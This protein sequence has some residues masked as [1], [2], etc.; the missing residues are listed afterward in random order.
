[1]TKRRQ[2]LLR[3]S[4][5][6]VTAPFIEPVPR[7]KA[8]DHAFADFVDMAEGNPLSHFSHD[9]RKAF[10]ELAVSGLF[11]GLPGDEDVLRKG[12]FKPYHHQVEMLARGV[13]AGRPG[14]VTSGTGSG[15]TESFMLPILATMAEEAVTWPE[16]QSGYLSGT[17]WKNTPNS[18]R[19]HREYE[20]PDR[21][22]ALRAL[23]LYPM[24]ALVE[25]QL[26]RLR[27]TFDSPEAH[28][29][30]DRRF[31]G[32]R[33]FF[34]RYT[35]ATPV[36]GWL[37]HPRRAHQRSEQ[38][39][40]AR[41]TKRVADAFVS[42]AED[43][44]LAQ[45]HDLAHGD[46]DPTRYLFP[47]VDGAELISRW[48]MQASPPDL[49]VTNISMLGAMLSREIEQP[50]FDQTRAWLERDENAYFFLVLDEL[51]L[52]R[53]SAGTE[54]AGLL[55][56]LVH[57]LGLD[58]PEIRHKLRILASS[59]SLPL[60][61]DEGERSLKYLFDFFG[62]LGTYAAPGV[63]GAA[64]KEGWAAAIVPGQPEIDQVEARLPLDKSPFEALVDLISPSGDYVGVA[65]RSNGLDEVIARCA[66][67]LLPTNAATNTPAIVKLAVEASAALLAA[68]C[69]VDG[70]TQMRATAADELARRIFGEP[71]ST[72]M[73]AM[74]GLTL[75]RGLGERLKTL[76]GVGVGEGITSFREHIFIR[77]IEGLFATPVRTLAGGV[78]FDGVTVERG[79]TYS[80]EGEELRRI[81]ELVYCES[82]GEEFVGGRRG[83]N[84]A[85]PGLQVELL[86]A[87][88][89]LESLPETAG[90]GNYEDLSYE[91][92]A[93]FWP[94]RRVAKKGEN[95][96]EAWVEAMLDT[97]NGVV[98]AAG[99]VGA[100][101]IEGRI[102]IL[103]RRNG[104][105]ELR[106]PGSA[107]PNCCPACGADYHPRS[108]PFRRS[109]I[110]NFRTGFAKSSQLVATEVFELLHAGRDVA[111]AVVFSDSR[112]DASRTALDIE[113]RHHQD[114]R[115]QMLLEALREI[116]AKPT[117]PIEEVKA[118]RLEALAR[119]D[120]VE[121]A[122]L[123]AKYA[124]LKRRGD[125]DRIPLASVVE[126][127]P[128]VDT[129]ARRD[130]S[131]LLSRMVDIGMHP[132][133]EI[134]IAKIP[135]NVPAAQRSSQFEW[136]NL[137]HLNGHRTEW[138]TNGDS[139]AVGTA[140]LAV[141]QEQRPLV[142]DVLFSKTYFALEETGLGYPSL[143][144]RK[145]ADADR[146]DS[147]LRVFA[148]AYRVR[149]NKWVER[150]DRR[151]DWPNAHAIGTRR[152]LD[153]ASAS[154]GGD[155]LA[156]LDDVLTKLRSLGHQ[157]GFIEPEKLT[158]RVVG[159]DHPYFECGN[160]SR[161]HLH[162]GTGFCTRCLE[163]LPGEPT[164]RVSE[165]RARNVLA[166]RVERSAAEGLGA[167]RLRCEELTG[168]TSSPAERL[169]RFRG[170]FVDGAD[171]SGT[172]LNRRAKEIDM[173]SV[174]TTMEVGI[175]IGALQAVYQA[176]MP[177]QRFNYQQR[178]GRAGRR[179]QAFSLVAT[180]CRS[181]SHDLHY[182]AHP[183]AITGDPPPPP[184][185]TIDHLDIP[186]R[187]LRKVWLGAA[188]ARLRDAAGI[189]WPGD[190]VKPDIHG[191][192]LPCQVFYADD[193]D[194]PEELENALVC[195]DGVRRSFARVL[196]L[197]S[198]E[199]EKALLAVETASEL[200]AN[201]LSLAQAGR[202]AEGTLASFLAEQGF[203]PMY[204]MPTRVR[205]L[206]VG[207]EEND[208]GESD[209]DTIDREMDLAIYEFAP[210]RSLV[211]DKRKHTSVGFTPPLGRIRVGHQ[212]RA[213]IIGT[214]TSWWG[215]T[216]Y[217]AT[218]TMCSATNS[219][220][221]GV[222]QAVNCGDCQA[223]ISP[224]DFELYYLPAAFRTSFQPSAVDENESV[225]T[226]WRETSSEMER[227]EAKP[228]DGTNV[229][230]AAGSSARIIRR[231]RGPIGDNGKPGG[232]VI[233]E[234]VQKDI[235]VREAPAAWVSRIPRQAV[236]P[237]VLDNPKRWERA[238]DPSG[239]P[240]EA[241]TVRLMSRKK[242]D[243]LYLL[244]KEIPQGLAYDRI[245][246]RDPYTTSM[247]ASAISATHLL[248]QRAALE[249]DIGPEE[250]EVLEPRLRDGRPL[251][252]IAD[253]LVNGA[254]FCRRLASADGDAP[255]VSRLLESLVYD[256]SDR[257][258][259]SFLQDDHRQAC[260]RSCY[261][262]MQRY[263][264]RGYHGLLDWRL[265]M[266]FI[267]AM[268]ESGWTAGLDGRWATPELMDWPRLACE[269]AEE[270]R[271]LDPDNRQ[272]EHHGPLD[273]PVLLRP[274]GDGHEAFVIVHPFWRLDHASVTQGP[275]ADTVRSVRSRAQH[276]YFVD[277]FD[278][279]RRPVKAIEQARL[280]TP[281]K[282]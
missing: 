12:V 150:N 161:A 239:A 199:R 142:D 255:L 57:R 219:S 260:A 43:Q 169:R 156:E 277:T 171:T 66:R 16:P 187:L 3:T 273:L 36:A 89:D 31:A 132:T 224:D 68:A 1:M 67:I 105:A 158:I 75:L 47:S 176:N 85:N 98:S 10:A 55:R 59:A 148:D 139:L 181:R 41:R 231:N 196:S 274:H 125:A 214:G 99:K 21:P 45:A 247:R 120:D 39:A 32:N 223:E 129:P 104:G 74:R 143:F 168:Q 7:Y 275:L 282:I 83:E 162:R 87:S 215:D 126:T 184:F 263:N 9:G 213:S 204:G 23:V 138:T 144:A 240:V 82:C 28:K 131:P 86:P 49:L 133:D 163:S 262:C 207:V 218:C 137:F 30:M 44:A 141:V 205:D 58:Q 64:S 178:V 249:M 112:Q 52:V 73:K 92:F 50:I 146:M 172:E 81:F 241:E 202:A 122:I 256:Q 209:W 195:T 46:E 157:N 26:T 151:K 180:L 191:E 280:R 71:A 62:P 118:R 2:E 80:R 167:F 246:N 29:V 227:L 257:L 70:G 189:N 234:A 51:H 159:N 69:R 201:I 208:V 15:K 106:V 233:L 164:A 152:I 276:V 194:W 278:V 13:H 123:D 200:M 198:A 266:G 117:E 182:F 19:L 270:V 72:S 228:V 212:G 78:E 128:A 113:R 183:E 4:G 102:F 185:L 95:D 109:P 155:R 222:F 101:R 40:S 174:T 77:S 272:V 254:G 220:E 18:F 88:P 140:R 107:G 145:E 65:E 130:V 251:L 203:L 103:P 265:G 193:S 33:I 221:T 48:D 14:I 211:R 271:R 175:D 119:D 248:V 236:V 22:K 38:E 149:G 100:D 160:C 134:G 124:E 127:A 79:T 116:A 53:G 110:R 61:G 76:Y 173:L 269:A 177:P 237:D 206:Y 6:L 27:K 190:D 56:A 268:L 179:G 245:G 111:K 135:G 11:P 136:Q 250:F 93:I 147:Y 235:K 259:Q 230:L 279:A 96:A 94:S 253:F 90:D 244:M 225:L 264:N 281:D 170:I 154:S 192:F 242:T 37:Q 186:L 20:H 91:D 232:F 8:A 114:S 35:G 34:G 165:L 243:S 166:R 97:R 153:F 60:Q 217:I 267:R 54:I 42:Y 5:A 17:W 63:E 238:N 108:A 115:R 84:S 258:V 252:Q 188:F 261:R 25:D 229:A 226:V 216:A 210:G 121:F 197:G 24:N